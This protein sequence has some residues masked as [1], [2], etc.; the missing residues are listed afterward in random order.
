MLASPEYLARHGRPDSPLNWAS[1]SAIVY[2]NTSRWDF[3]SEHGRQ[4][5]EISGPLRINDAD[6]ICDAVRANLGIA[7]VPDWIIKDD[8]AAQGLVPLL[9]DYYPIPKPCQHHLPVR[10]VS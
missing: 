6:S 9:D 7:Q 10:L 5:V 8:F 3:E 1:I 4:S 2:G